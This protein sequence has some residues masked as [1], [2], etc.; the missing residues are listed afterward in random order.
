MIFIG[1][2][3]WYFLGGKIKVIDFMMGLVGIENFLN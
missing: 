2:K 1:E 3:F